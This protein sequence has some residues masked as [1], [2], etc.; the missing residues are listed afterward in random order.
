[1]KR[2][3]AKHLAILTLGIAGAF[4]IPSNGK[5]D[6]FPWGGGCCGSTYTAGYFP[7]YTGYFPSYY[8]AGYYGAGY[9]GAGY[10]GGYMTSAT[11]ADI[12][13]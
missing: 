6:F 11:M 4:V 1:M 5:A 10:Y 9:Y 12:T 2:Q 8:G 7:S 13:R 3:L